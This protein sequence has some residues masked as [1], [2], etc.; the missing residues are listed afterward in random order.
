MDEIRQR[1][2]PF[3]LNF[4]TPALIRN[5]K[6]DLPSALFIFPFFENLHS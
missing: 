4:H 5:G 1:N 2:E 3:D 6:T